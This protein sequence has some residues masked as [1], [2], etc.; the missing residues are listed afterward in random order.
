MLAVVME[1]EDKIVEIVRT[2]I[3]MAGVT[4]P[5]NGDGGYDG[6]AGGIRG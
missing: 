4:L 5:Q 6:G 2:E 1:K 3:E